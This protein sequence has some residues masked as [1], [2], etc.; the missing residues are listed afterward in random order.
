[1]DRI[2]REALVQEDRSPAAPE[3]M[4]ASPAPAEQPEPIA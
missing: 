2:I 3:A 4:T 1:V